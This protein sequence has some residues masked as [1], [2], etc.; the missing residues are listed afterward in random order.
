MAQT[1]AQKVATAAI[2]AAIEQY[3]LAF[4]EANPEATNGVL[5][6]WV[7]V[8]AETIPDMDD[9]ADDV[10]AYSVIMAGGGMA[11]YRARGLLAAGIHYMTF[12]SGPVGD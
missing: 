1:E 5:G 12:D 7:L 9:P 10:T 8:A 11:W 2:E 6:D 4:R 3:R